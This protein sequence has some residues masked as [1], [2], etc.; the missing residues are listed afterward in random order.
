MFFRCCFP[1]LCSLQACGKVVRYLQSQLDGIQIGLDGKNVDAVL[2]EL[3]YRVHRVVYDHIL[4]YTYNSM[5]K[6]QKYNGYNQENIFL[7]YCSSERYFHYI[8]FTV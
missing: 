8:R 5:G 7:R 1:V 3:G 6:W 2:T 4:Q